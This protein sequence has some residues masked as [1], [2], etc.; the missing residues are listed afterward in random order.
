MNMTGRIT[1][2][3]V[4]LMQPSQM[5]FEAITA[6]CNVATIKHLYMPF[7]KGEMTIGQKRAYAR[8]MEAVNNQHTKVIRIGRKISLPFGSNKIEIIPQEQI[9]TSKE[10]AYRSLELKARIEN[11]TLT[12]C[13]SKMDMGLVDQRKESIK[14][15][16]DFA[17]IISS[18]VRART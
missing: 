11:Q 15:V 6:L 2:D 3:H 10:M 7:W 4:I 9:I 5:S 12:C 14:K 18:K 13:S 17:T 16:I 1:V 8:L